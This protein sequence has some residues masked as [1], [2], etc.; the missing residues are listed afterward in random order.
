MSTNTKH[1]GRNETIS[2]LKG[3]SPV[4]PHGESLAM[5]RKPYNEA[6]DGFFL[7][8]LILLRDKIVKRLKID[9]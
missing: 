9:G 1:K 3:R 4:F 5:E 6:D 7:F 2:T 8:N